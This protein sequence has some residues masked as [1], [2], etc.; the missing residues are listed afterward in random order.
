[1]IWKLIDEHAEHGGARIHLTTEGLDAGPILTYC[2]FPLRGPTIDL[3]WRKAEGR[4]SR[5]IQEAEGEALPLFVEI[6]RR[7]VMREPSLLIHTARALATGGLRIEGDQIFTD[8]TRVTQGFDLTPEIEA[9]L[10]NVM[11]V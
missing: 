3:L 9:D 6:R 4:T 10:A 11:P 8:G 1:V 2:A 7:G 5:D